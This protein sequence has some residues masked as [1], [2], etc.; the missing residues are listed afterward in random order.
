MMVLFDAYYLCHTVMQ[1]YREKHFCR[2]S[3]L[4]SNRR[5]FK[6]GWKLNAGRYGKNLFRRHCT[7]TLVT[8]KPHGHARYGYLDAGWLEVS[9]LH[10][11]RLGAQGQGKRDKA[12]DR[13][14]AAAQD[15]LRWLVRDGLVTSLK[16]KYQDESVLADLEQLRVA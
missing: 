4:K 16:E 14:T 3:T 11:E 2:V 10:I 13:S 1:A 15:Q 8:V 7:E 6:Q 9:T 5:L 12:A